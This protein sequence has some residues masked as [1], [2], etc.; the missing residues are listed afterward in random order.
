M[1]NQEPICGAGVDELARLAV[2][3]VT[4]DVFG[5]KV[6]IGAGFPLDDK[7]SFGDSFAP[8]S[9]KPKLC[10]HATEGPNRFR[11]PA[12][13]GT[14]YKDYSPDREI[15]L[16]PVGKP[17]PAVAENTTSAGSGPSCTLRTGMTSENPVG[18][19]SL[20]E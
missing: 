1:R 7:R 3:R 14:G 20:T 16:A 17:R 12:T 18:S 19:P 13:K 11:S 15:R 6:G 2:V 5:D 9:R 4:A 8:P 10:E